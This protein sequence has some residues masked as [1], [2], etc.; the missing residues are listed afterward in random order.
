MG[1]G[2]VRV[3]NDMFF[4]GRSKWRRGHGRVL[5]MGMNGSSTMALKPVCIQK[6]TKEKNHLKHQR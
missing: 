6:Q 5:N 3:H 4:S 1:R 2:G